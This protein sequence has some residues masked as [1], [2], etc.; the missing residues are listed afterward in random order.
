MLAV[1]VR[2]LLRCRVPVAERRVGILNSWQAIDRITEGRNDIR[3]SP[4]EAQ[5]RFDDLLYGN[6]R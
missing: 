6:W 5:C 4:D 2:R 1:I 3:A